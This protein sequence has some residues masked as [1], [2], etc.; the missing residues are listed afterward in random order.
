M[1]NIKLLQKFDLGG[2]V[3]SEKDIDVSP[4]FDG[5]RRKI[6]VIKLKN[7]NALKKHKANEPITILCLAGGGRFLAGNDLEE[8]LN[9]IAGSFIT[10]EPGV[11]HEIHP[12]PDIS[13]LL[14]KFTE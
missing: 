7:G 9:L 6:I 10:L 12:D 5:S 13:I 8:S 11:E 1:K 14:T 2:A 4:L 3:V